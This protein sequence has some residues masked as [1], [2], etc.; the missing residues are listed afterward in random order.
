MSKTQKR[1]AINYRNTYFNGQGWGGFDGA[2]LMT[3]SRANSIATA[4]NTQSDVPYWVK[5]V[6]V[7]KLEKSEIL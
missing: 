4:M 5:I 3:L 1:Y 2:M 6:D 7:T